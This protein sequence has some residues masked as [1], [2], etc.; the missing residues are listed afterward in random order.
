MLTAG[1]SLAVFTCLASGFAGVLSEKLLKGGGGD[2]S[3]HIANI[4]LYTFGVIVNGFSAVM[5]QMMTDPNNPFNV[6]GGFNRYAIL[7]AFMS[8]CTGLMTAL[9][10]KYFDVLIKSFSTTAAMV[11]MYITS[12]VFFGKNLSLPFSC[13]VAVLATA[14]YIYN[15]IAR[16]LEEARTL[17]CKH[18]PET[19]PLKGI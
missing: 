18:T 15:I 10:L 5:R 1:S 11:L 4:K 14:V 8:A 19:T 9:V 16:E 13:A 17:L 12:I 3:I 6:F 7:A 2:D